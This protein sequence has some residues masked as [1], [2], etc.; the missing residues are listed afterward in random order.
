LGV[1]QIVE[2]LGRAQ[3]RL[4]RNAAP[5]ETDA[6]EIFPFDNGRLETELRRADGGDVAARP[7]A[8]DDDVEGGISHCAHSARAPRSTRGPRPVLRLHC[9]AVLTQSLFIAEN[10]RSACSNSLPRSAGGVFAA[11]LTIF[12]SSQVR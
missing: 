5:V 4:G 9:L 12:S 6:A 1:L 7:R 2:N 10:I 11:S 3:Q 8:D